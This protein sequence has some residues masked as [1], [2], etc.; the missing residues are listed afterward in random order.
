[1]RPQVQVSG[2]NRL[3]HKLREIRQ[4]L[5]KQDV[6]VGLPKGSGQYEDGTP[7][8]VIGAVQEFG[9]A[10]GH[11]PE[12]SFLRVPLRAN[13]ELFAN[14][15]REMIPKV[16]RGELDMFQMLDQV[17]AKAAGV[18]QEAISEGIMPPNADSTKQ[19]KGSDTPLVADGDL[20]RSITYVVQESDQ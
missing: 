4:R 13:Q 2:G 16:V 3:S 12:R 18:S 17:G 10:D 15:F 5:A 19:R 8:A 14:I 6:Y 1:M 9:S 11:I 7:M 20:R